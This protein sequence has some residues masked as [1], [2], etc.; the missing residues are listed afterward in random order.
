M[1]TRMHFLDL[2]AIVAYDRCSRQSWRELFVRLITYNYIQV[3]AYRSLSLV[4][5]SANR[6]VCF[7]LEFC[8]L[9]M[10]WSGC[11]VELL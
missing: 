1:L 9:L 4:S 7:A 11:D 8:P 3:S 5:A 6:S 2:S 10:N